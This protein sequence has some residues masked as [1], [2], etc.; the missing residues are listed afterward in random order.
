[1][2]D[3]GFGRVVMKEED[4]RA[5]ATGK[6]DLVAICREHNLTDYKIAPPRQATAK[7]VLLAIS[8]VRESAAGAEE[9]GFKTF[10]VDRTQLIDGADNVVACQNMLWKLAHARSEL[11]FEGTKRD[12]SSW[13]EQTETPVS[14]AKKV[15][16]LSN[17]PTDAS[18]P[19]GM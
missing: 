19:G 11:S 10:M 1:M 15:R 12:R 7:Y 16:R 3:V 8:S 18:L 13:S 4:C 14:S 5:N 2:L 6:Y 17:S 9:P